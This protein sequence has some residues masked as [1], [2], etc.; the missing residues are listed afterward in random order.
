[1]AAMGRN[2]SL[3]FPCCRIL[4]IIVS[5]KYSFFSQRGW[6]KS[7]G[8]D[9]RDI[10]KKERKKLWKRRERQSD[11]GDLLWKLNAVTPTQ[12]RHVRGCLLYG[13]SF[14]I[15]MTIVI[16]SYGGHKHMRC[17]GRLLGRMLRGRSRV[18]TRSNSGRGGR[19]IMSQR[20]LNILLS[21]SLLPLSLVL[22]SL[23]LLIVQQAVTRS[24]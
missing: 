22:L 9:T 17:E 24:R 7:H 6:C 15:R 20:T 1:M 19:L 16:P 8:R 10:Q 21:P 18:A 12:V 14:G 23:L 2:G 4:T 13:V 3:I 5:S 11:N